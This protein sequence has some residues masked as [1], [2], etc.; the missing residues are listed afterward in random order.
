MTLQD[1]Y[2]LPV[3]SHHPYAV[4]Q[5]SCVYFHGRGFVRTR[6]LFKAS[7]LLALPL[8]N[9][10]IDSVNN[11]TAKTWRENG[12]FVVPTNIA[13]IGFDSSVEI[14]ANFDFRLIRAQ[15]TCPLTKTRTMPFGER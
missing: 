7:D 4:S 13:I 12:P 10:R 3:E 8:G 9:G 5:R 1:R 6:R 2:I 15:L 14:K 11:L